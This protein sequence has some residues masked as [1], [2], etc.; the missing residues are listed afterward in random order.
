L[1]LLQQDKF[2]KGREQRT[3][4]IARNLLAEGFEAAIVAK[5]TGI[6]PDDLANRLRINS[7]ANS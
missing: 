5:T 3:L 7:K 2:E 6:S 1:E 4:E